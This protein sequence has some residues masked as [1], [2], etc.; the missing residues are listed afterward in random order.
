M[1]VDKLQHNG[2]IILMAANRKARLGAVVYRLWLCSE[3][4]AGRRACQRR[5]KLAT[6]NA[7]HRLPVSRACSSS[8]S[9][10][11]IIKCSTRRPDVRWPLGSRQRRETHVRAAPSSSGRRRRRRRRTN[12]VQLQLCASGHRRGATGRFLMIS[13]SQLATR[14]LVVAGPA[15]ERSRLLA[16]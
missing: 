14:Q 16:E 15:R 6:N 1:H 8:G 5:G 4:R 12:Q 3:A 13:G 9:D 11:G 10:F 2:A 7:L